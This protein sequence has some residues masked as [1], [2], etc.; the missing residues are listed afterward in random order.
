MDYRDA[1]VT[2]FSILKK[3]TETKKRGVFNLFYQKK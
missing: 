2:Y 3:K 1:E